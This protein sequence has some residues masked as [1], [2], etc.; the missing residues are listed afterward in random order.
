MTSID[1]GKQKAIGV[2]MFLAIPGSHSQYLTELEQGLSEASDSDVSDSSDSESS[3]SSSES[4]AE[5]T[6]GTLDA[7]I[8]KARKNAEAAEKLFQT[9]EDD[10]DKE[11]EVITLDNDG[12]M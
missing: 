10:Q 1:K 2:L 4:E 7:L 3:D 9:P 5:I 12:H 8:E 6:Q 11:E